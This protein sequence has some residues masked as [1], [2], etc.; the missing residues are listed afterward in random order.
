MAQAARAG[1]SPTIAIV[2]AW[3]KS[4][5]SKPVKVAPTIVAACLVDD[6]PRGAAGA[7]AL[8]AG[9]GGAVGG[10]VDR[11]GVEPGLFGLR[12]RLADRR[13]LRVGEGDPRRADAFGDRLDLAAE[14]VL[15]RDPGLVLA[16]VGEE[17][18]AVDVADR[19]EPLAAADPQPVVGLE[20]A[21]LVGLDADRCRGRA[22]RCAGCGR[23]RRGSPLASTLPPSLSST[24][25]PP[26]PV[27]H[28]LGLDAGADVDAEALAQRLR[29]PPRRRRAP[30]GRAGA[31]RPRPG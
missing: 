4:A 25:T 29:P 9:A 24:T 15:G 19:V 7:L 13:H 23:P 31:R 21:V 2:A 28:L 8:E 20:E 26:P 16:D 11:A 22:R 12:Q 6:D 10:D 3:R 27:R 17:G 30:R 1:T 5:V 14:Q 18:T